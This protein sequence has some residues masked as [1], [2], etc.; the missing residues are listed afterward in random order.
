MIM[1]APQII[2]I[3]FIITNIYIFTFVLFI[4]THN[5]QY[6]TDTK[7]VKFSK[8]TMLLRIFEEKLRGIEEEKKK[9]NK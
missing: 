3:I 1:P 9:K 6:I 7:L 4:I 2:I 5:V 8:T